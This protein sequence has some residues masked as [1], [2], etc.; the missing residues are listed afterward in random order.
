MIDSLK[1]AVRPAQGFMESDSWSANVGS[2]L[3]RWSG[4]RVEVGGRL[5]S[6]FSEEKSCRLDRGACARAAV[7]ADI[8]SLRFERSYNQAV[9]TTAINPPSSAMSLAP[10]SDL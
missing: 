1:K 7:D 2:P 5:R 3:W 8:S 4:R 6:R 10:S 9:Q